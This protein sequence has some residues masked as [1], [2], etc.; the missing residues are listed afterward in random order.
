MKKVNDIAKCA[1][2]SIYNFER[3]ISDRGREQSVGEV[4]KGTNAGGHSVDVTESRSNSRYI[5][6]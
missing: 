1:I 6:Y 4:K 2:S 5:N 3:E